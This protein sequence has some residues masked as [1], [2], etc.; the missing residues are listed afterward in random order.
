MQGEFKGGE[1]V[2]PE[3]NLELLPQLDWYCL[4]VYFFW[5]W[6]HVVCHFLKSKCYLTNKD[7]IK[8]SKKNCFLSLAH[9]NLL[10]D[11]I[12][13][14]FQFTGNWQESAT[15]SRFGN[16]ISQGPQ[17]ADISTIKH[18]F[19]PIPANGQDGINCSTL[20][21]WSCLANLFQLKSKARSSWLNCAL[22]G[23]EA[24]YWL[25]IGQQC[26]LLDGTLSQHE[27]KLVGN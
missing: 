10:Q 4:I 6:L 25:S 12:T 3:S 21:V 13:V 15:S 16:V 22:R 19:L 8:M 26:L 1:E 5:D 20:T 11:N 24:V 7:L 14:P 17:F 23:D 9:V 27:T 18:W 2:F